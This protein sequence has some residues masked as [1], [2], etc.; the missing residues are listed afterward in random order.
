MQGNDLAL[1]D[2]WIGG[3]IEAGG[4]LFA[5]HFSA[6]YRFFEAKT[7]GDVDDLVQETFLACL[8]SQ[9]SFRRQS[10]FRTYLLAIARHVLFHHWRNRRTSGTR[11]D[12]EEVSIASL[13]TSAGSKLAMAQE[14]VAIQS[15]LRQLPL[16]TQ[17]LLELFYW[18]EM[19]RDSLA[20]VFD[21]ESST[22]GTRLFRA[23]NLLKERMSS[24]GATEVVERFLMTRR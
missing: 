15:A 1:L 14:R 16:D 3:D 23:R 6:V 18:E 13:S 10:S 8:K 9:Q 20:E 11:L 22:I 24:T 2:Q 7:D 19:D 21:V 17:L 4:E 5:R 12:F